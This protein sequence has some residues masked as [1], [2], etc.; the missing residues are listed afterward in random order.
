MKT[1]FILL[2]GFGGSYPMVCSKKQN[3]TK[4][5]S[6]LILQ[7]KSLAQTNMLTYSSIQSSFTLTPKNTIE[8]YS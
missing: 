6:E 7:Q 8:I 2:L 4:Q 3:K 5:E 1:I